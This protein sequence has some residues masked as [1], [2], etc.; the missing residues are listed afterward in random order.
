[1]NE[2]YDNA[3]ITYD[4]FEDVFGR[5]PIDGKDMRLLSSVHYSKHHDD[6]FWDGKQMVY[7]NGDGVVFGSFTKAI[8]VIAH[9]LTHAI[10]QMTC[11]L[12]YHGESGALNESISDVFGSM[13]KQWHFKQ[14]VHEADWLIGDGLIADK[15]FGKA[16]RSLKA[17]GT[18]YNNM[19]MG[20]KDPQPAHYRDYDHSRSDEGGV[21]VNSGIP[22]HAFYL[23][24]MALGEHSWK[25]AGHVWFQA[26]T[27]GDISERCSFKRFAE[28]TIE[29]SRLHGSSVETTVRKAWHHVGVEPGVE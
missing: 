17:P 22:N 10:T 7:G 25:T 9:E 6:A 4:F 16:L 8:D 14:T 19:W 12:A 23:A 26:I 5:R 1:M 29:V 24:A 27:D 11:G 15:R 18:A 28:K 13:V 2:A 3:G 21:H 20:G